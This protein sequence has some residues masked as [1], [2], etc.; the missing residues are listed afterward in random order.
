MSINK[1]QIRRMCLIDTAIRSMVYPSKQAIMEY[2]KESMTGDYMSKEICAS[3]IE[4]DMY[5]MKMEYDA[6]IKFKKVSRQGYYY[7]SDRDFEFWKVFLQHWSL[8]IDFPSFIK[9]KIYE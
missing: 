1:N 5:F 6:P 7:Y 3:T 4:K 8:F 2:V 9:Q